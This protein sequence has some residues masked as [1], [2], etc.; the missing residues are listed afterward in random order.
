[1]TA[2]V[3]SS[4]LAGT[5]AEASGAVDCEGS[6]AMLEVVG[7][8]SSLQCGSVCVERE[9]ERE[10]RERGERERRERE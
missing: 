5:A 6:V 9:G 10:E 3:P 4:A 8:V 2:A 1:L 7:D